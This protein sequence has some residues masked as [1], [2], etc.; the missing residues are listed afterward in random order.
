MKRTDVV[1][2]ATFISLAVATTPAWAGDPTGGPIRHGCDVEQ[3]G[4]PLPPIGAGDMPPPPPVATVVPPPITAPATQVPL[5]PA[6]ELIPPEERRYLT[7]IPLAASG[8]L[9]EGEQDRIRAG[10]AAADAALHGR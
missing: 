7:E 8:P 2:A 4:I 10:L 3:T 1:A 6:V 5:P 9:P